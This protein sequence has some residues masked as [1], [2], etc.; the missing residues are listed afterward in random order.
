MI[1]VLA[2]LSGCVEFQKIS[3]I[4]N[5]A[6][7]AVEMTSIADAPI[8]GAL[9]NSTIRNN[10]QQKPGIT[11][12]AIPQTNIPSA[13][14]TALPYSVP[15]SPVPTPPPVTNYSCNELKNVQKQVQLLLNDRLQKNEL[16]YKYQSL[17]SN[18]TQN[19]DTQ[20]AASYQVQIDELQRMIGSLDQQ[21]SSLRV[22]ESIL[23]RECYRI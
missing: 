12:S 3:T 23:S 16:L 2:L 18:A 1:A 7:P 15:P 9:P 20:S 22:R 11:P 4:E 6:T 14:S 17:K 10:P 5:S 19:G 8:P 21:L 13:T